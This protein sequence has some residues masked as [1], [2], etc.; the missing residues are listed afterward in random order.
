MKIASH[1]ASF[2]D[3]A[4]F[5]IQDQALIEAVGGGAIDYTN[6]NGI[7]GACADSVCTGNYVC[8]TNGSCVR[9]D[10]VCPTN[11]G[12]VDFFC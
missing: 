5:T 2:D 3:F 1:L 8:G 10:R 11:H 6:S 7:N 4:V 9:I 12:C